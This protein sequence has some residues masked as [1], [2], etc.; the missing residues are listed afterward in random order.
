MIPFSGWGVRSVREP[1]E[2]PDAGSRAEYAEESLASTRGGVAGSGPRV[3]LV[4]R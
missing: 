2:M 3:L 4:V 1:M